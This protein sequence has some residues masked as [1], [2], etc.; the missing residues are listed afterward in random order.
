MTSI[1]ENWDLFLEEFGY[2]DC[3]VWYVIKNIQATPFWIN[4]QI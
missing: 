4:L 1:K 3:F 2:D